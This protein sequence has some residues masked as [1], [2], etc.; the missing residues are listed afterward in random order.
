MEFPDLVNALAR[1]LKESDGS[2]TLDQVVALIT[3]CREKGMNYSVIALVKIGLSKIGA[4]FDSL[5]TTDAP[6]PQYLEAFFRLCQE[7][8][9]VSFYTDSKVLGLALSDRL[10]FSRQAQTVINKSMVHGNQFFYIEQLPINRRL[11]VPATMPVINDRSNQQYFPLNPSIVAR[12]D[13]YL[14]LCRGVNYK[15]EHANNYISQDSDGKIRTRN[16]LIKTDLDFKPL[17]QRE[18]VDRSDR[19]S[20]PTR[21]GGLVIG[22]EDCHLI[23]NKQGELR[24]TCTT[25]DTNPT[26]SP[27]ISLCRIPSDTNSEGNYEVT[28]VTPLQGPNPNRCEKNW[29]PFYTDSGE[30]WTIYGYDP[31]VIKKICLDKDGRA[32]GILEDQINR[33]S[34]LDLSRFRGSGGPILLTLKGELGRLVVIHEVI[35][36]PQG[37][38]YFHRFLWF[39][40]DF[41]LTRMS[42]PWFLDHK[43][44]E[45]CKSICKQVTGRNLLLGIGI[46]DCEAWIYQ[47]SLETVQAM[48]KPIVVW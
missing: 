40:L 13:H 24:F 42:L 44:I 38:S 2:T 39:D 27:Q 23:S 15:Q 29:L 26:G 14:I 35:P 4:S 22:L 6:P 48:L 25:L 21:L 28:E 34:R 19:T 18:I 43:G 37:R 30:V 46:E 32:T 5:A 41:K 16:F 36:R 1:D 17:W 33:D 7:I 11:A 20:C 31:I 8:S 45:F 9:I 10:L 12:I 3:T 47:M